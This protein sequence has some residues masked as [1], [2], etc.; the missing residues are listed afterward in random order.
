MADRG[1]VSAVSVPSLPQEAPD[2]LRELSLRD[3]LAP[4]REATRG[5]HGALLHYARQDIRQLMVTRKEDHE[6]VQEALRVLEAL[7]E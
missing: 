6:L 7:E 1:A 4:V 2:S 5:L 3:R